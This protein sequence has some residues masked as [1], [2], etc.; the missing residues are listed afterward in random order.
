M[1]TKI[2]DE[3]LAEIDEIMKGAAGQVDAVA[4]RHHVATGGV[5]KFS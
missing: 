3:V 1:E 5:T 4:G 2:P